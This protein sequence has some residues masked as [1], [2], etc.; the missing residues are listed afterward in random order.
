MHEIN[1][2]YILLN[3]LVKARFENALL[4]FSCVYFVVESFLFAMED[5]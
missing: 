2:G 1:R 5:M 3:S 4:F